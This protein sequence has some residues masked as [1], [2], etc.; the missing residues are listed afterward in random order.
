MSWLKPL[1][2]NKK[3]LEATDQLAQ[4]H[5]RLPMRMYIK[6]RF[7]ALNFK[8]L[9]ETFVTDNFFSSEKAYGEYTCAQPFAKKVSSYIEV[10][11]MKRVE[12]MPKIFKV[13]SDNGEHLLNYLKI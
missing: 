12:K 13:S 10:Y 8:R 9:R 1:N 7:P 6:S 11:G 4:K 2:F 3:P 5:V